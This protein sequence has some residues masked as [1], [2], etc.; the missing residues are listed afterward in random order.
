MGSRLALP[1]RSSNALTARWT[2]TFADDDAVV[3]GAGLWPLLAILAG[4]AHGPAREELAA[5]V[6]VSAG[7]A[8]AAGLELLRVFDSSSAVAAA[9]GAW[10]RPGMTF[11]DDW[12]RTMPPGSTGTLTDQAALDDW[13]RE[14]TGGLIEKFPVPVGPSTL[15][16]L[17]TALVARTRWV[18]PFT[19]VTYAPETGP[20]QGH[21]G[22][23]LCRR[24]HPDGS[25]AVLGDAVTR[26][27]VTGTDD[28]DVHLLIGADPNS[29]LAAGLAALDD[30]IPVRTDLPVDTTAPGL[31]VTRR[32]T[33][34][35]GDS[36]EM[37]LPPF[38]V[39]DD[40]DLTQHASLFGLVTALGSSSGHFPGLSDQPLAVSDA[41]QR[42]LARFDAAGFEAAAVTAISLRAGS[43]PVE[44]WSTI[45]SVTVERP[46][47]FLAVH[48]RSG[49]V[50][51][52]GQV[53]RP[54][55]GWVRSAGADPAP[56]RFPGR[57]R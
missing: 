27:I 6:G 16:A 23:G 12:V 5:A 55:T 13:A 31:T 46:F 30:A 26:V 19:E 40:H 14:H 10:I 8:H 45:T 41:R 7:T 37:Q 3:S 49:L 53:T 11:R 28:L 18:T 25:V 20:W 44:Q 17:A 48:R 43:A 35:V 32:K 39:N 1:V 51:V 34:G 2:T 38:E 29:A 21:Q 24:T 56:G 54:A 33:R 36:I 42:V 47:G 57:P 22:P 4:A 9:I 15:F 50:L 52:A